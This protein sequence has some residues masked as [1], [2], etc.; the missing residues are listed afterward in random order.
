MFV[1]VEHLLANLDGF[2]AHV[3]DLCH[4]LHRNTQKKYAVNTL[5]HVLHFPLDVKL[6]VL[7]PRIYITMSLRETRSLQRGEVCMHPAYQPQGAGAGV[8]GPQVIL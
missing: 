7:Q 3:L 6:L 4:S 2:V 1:V 8:S 5:M